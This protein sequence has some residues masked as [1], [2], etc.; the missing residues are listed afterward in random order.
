MTGKG[1]LNAVANGRA[2]VLQLLLE[3]LEEAGAAYCVPTASRW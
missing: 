3:I 1:F 2:D